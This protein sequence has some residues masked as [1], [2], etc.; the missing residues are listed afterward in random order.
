MSSY[1]GTC[2]NCFKRC[3]MYPAQ[4]RGPY[5]SDKCQEEHVKKAKEHT[6]RLLKSV[7][8]R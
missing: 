6:R 4:P 8:E 2:Q 3:E 7:K 5:C 1:T